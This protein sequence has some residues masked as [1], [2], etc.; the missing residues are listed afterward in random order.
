MKETHVPNR[1]RCRAL[2]LCL[3]ALLLWGASAASVRAETY[4]NFDCHCNPETES[5]AV[6]YI[7]PEYKYLNWT[8]KTGCIC[9]ESFTLPKSGTKEFRFRCKSDAAYPIPSFQAVFD[10]DKPTTCTDRFWGL[11]SVTNY[12]SLSCTNWSSLSTDQVKLQMVC[13]STPPP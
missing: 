5:A 6:P 13:T 8:V 10:R 1:S 11:E 12:T 7:D 9:E 4:H 2:A 3:S